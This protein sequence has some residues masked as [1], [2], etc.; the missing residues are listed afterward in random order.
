MTR[1]L[2]DAIATYRDMASGVRG[3]FVLT[4]VE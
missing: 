4:P 3:K 1:R 2:D